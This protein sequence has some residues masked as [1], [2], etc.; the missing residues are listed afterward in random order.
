VKLEHINQLR[1]DAAR[2]AFERCCGARAW[3][4]RM[5]AGRPYRNRAG[6][7]AAAERA[8]DK[9]KPADWLEAFA[10]HPRIGERAALQ[11]GAPA[12][13]AGSGPASSAA[14]AGEEQRGAAQAPQATLDALAAGQRAYE[15]QFGYIFIVCA[16]GK[17]ADEMLALLHARLANDPDT[18]LVN[19]AR[20][21]RAITR[22]RLEK[23]LSEPA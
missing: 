4:E 11:A 16:T 6:I 20:E 14:W 22:L 1:P 9:L 19:A 12:P 10:H 2:A 15:E 23:L 17:S 13:G 5:A 3:A 8:A 21:Q 7:F 18:E